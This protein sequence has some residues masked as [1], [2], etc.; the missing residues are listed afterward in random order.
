MSQS[1][2]KK[3]QRVLP[4]LKFKASWEIVRAALV[5]IFLGLA[6]GLIFLGLLALI[7]WLW[8]LLF[9]R[10]GSGVVVFFSTLVTLLLLSP[11]RRGMQGLVDYL[12]F[13]DTAGFLEKIEE[14]CRVLPEI[15]NRTDLKQF[16]VKKL[17][18]QWQVAY[19][20]LHKSSAPM[21]SDSLTLPLKTG[22]RSLGFLTIGPKYSGRSFSYEERLALERFQEQVSLVLSGIQLAEA[23]EAATKTDQLKSNFL[24][25]VSHELTTPLNVVIN[26][27]GLAADGALGPVS[28]EQAEYLNR[29]VSG[30][31][32]LMRLLN[33][34]LDITK[35]ETGQLTLRLAEID[36]REV[37]EDALSIMR[38]IL[39]NKAVELKVEIADDLPLVAADRTRI[40]QI[41]LNLL[42]N[43]EKFTKKGAICLRAWPQD[44]QVLISVQ[45]TGI[46]I[47]QENLPLIFEDYRQ[48]STKGYT[49][50]L[51]SRRRHQGT[52][53]GMP[54]ARALVE[55]HG[56][57]IEVASELGKGSFFTFTLP[58]SNNKTG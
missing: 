40:R 18:P 2:L 44:K 19:I 12:L 54:V 58:I 51:G 38:G 9:G 37:I 50:I 55:L 36:L 32:H 39:Q 48:V 15:N 5:W 33:E 25:N 28:K 35:I 6:T 29:A 26:S 42:S 17:P 53:L 31:E 47:A 20:T 11:L 45:D 57:Q 52:G 43:A 7:N 24:T 27:T 22:N 13:P 46:G 8:I 4:S 56:G 1:T 41:L 34:I 49:G 23:Q 21:I 14:A 10:G 16:L 3:N 30:S